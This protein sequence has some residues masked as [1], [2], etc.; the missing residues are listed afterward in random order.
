MSVNGGVSVLCMRCKMMENQS[1]EFSLWSQEMQV[2]RQ[3]L[4]FD[5]LKVL[6]MAFCRC[7][8]YLK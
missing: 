7:Q 1:L 8:N 4:S 3:S 2:F 5:S 6:A